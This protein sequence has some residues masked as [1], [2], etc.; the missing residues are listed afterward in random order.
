MP[1]GDATAAPG[2]QQTTEDGNQFVQTRHA[3]VSFGDL[4]AR[5]VIRFAGCGVRAPLLMAV[6]SRFRE[7]SA[8]RDASHDV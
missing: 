8:N 3:I 2:Q 4:N 5:R 1:T 7:R 6:S